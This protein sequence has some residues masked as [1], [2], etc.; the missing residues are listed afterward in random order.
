ME[1]VRKKYGNDADYD[2]CVFSSLFTSTH[3]IVMLNNYL[4]YLSIV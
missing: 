3:E 1:I 2:K 4:P